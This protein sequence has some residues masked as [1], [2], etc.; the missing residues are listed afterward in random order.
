MKARFVAKDQEIPWR[1]QALLSTDWLASDLGAFENHSSSAHTF[2]IRDKKI[3]NSWFC[4]GTRPEQNQLKRD[5]YLVSN[6]FERHKKYTDFVRN[7]TLVYCC[8][9]QTLPLG[10]VQYS[11]TGEE[12]P[13]S[14]HKHPRSERNLFQQLRRLKQN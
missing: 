12:H 5:E 8:G 9:G 6:V 10:L 7:S 2:L 4:K 13:V 1:M 14:P 11:Y 3:V